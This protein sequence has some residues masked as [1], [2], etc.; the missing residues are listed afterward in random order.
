MSL[1]RRELVEA[2]GFL[3]RL[4]GLVLKFPSM[5]RA[6]YVPMIDRL[7]EEFSAVCPPGVKPDMR[8]KLYNMDT[9]DDVKVVKVQFWGV[10]AV[11][12]EGLA[13]SYAQY[14]DEVHYKTYLEPVNKESI[15]VMQQ[16][17]YD[18][19][20]GRKVRQ[21]HNARSKGNSQERSKG[22]AIGD[23]DS[24]FEFVVYRKDSS[25]RYGLE[26]RI[27]GKALASVK[28]EARKVE[29]MVA[30]LGGNR[31]SLFF[32]TKDAREKVW[33]E[34][35]REL[36]TKGVDLGD[37]LTLIT[38]DQFV[39]RAPVKGYTPA[40]GQMWADD[41]SPKGGIVVQAYDSLEAFY[42]RLDDDWSTECGN[43]D[44]DEFLGFDA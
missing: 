43:P 38:P 11:Y 41:S 28:A 16:E 26:V 6:N 25:N 1:T 14:I 15:G 23:K 33:N 3:S 17:I 30:Q 8:V 44:I 21:T 2:M 9:A 36:D 32:A 12:A 7:R 22:V 5:P 24:S 29:A 4:D 37:Y 19:P 42:R 13:L 34:A 35:Y 40:S 18:A 10:Q 31:P 27:K 20:M 39:S